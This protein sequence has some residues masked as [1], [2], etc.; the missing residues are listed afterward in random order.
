MTPSSAINLSDA[1]IALLEQCA[2]NAWPALVTVD[3][4]GWALR[5]AGG[6]TKRA[7]SANA[8]APRH[9]FDSVRR[10]A[11]AHYGALGLPTIFRLSPL[12]P[13][14]ADA[15][16]AAAGYVLVDPSLV[17]VAA[18]DHGAA[19]SGA[20]LAPGPS[21]EWIEGIAKAS[22]E[23][24]DQVD[25]HAAIL[26]A[27]EAP[28]CFVTIHAQGIAAGFGL[29]VL[30]QGRLGLFDIAVLPAA[31]GQG[32][33]RAATRALLDWGRAQG[34]R[35]A[36]LQVTAANRVARGLYGSLGFAEAYSYH[37]RMQAPPCTLA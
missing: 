19:E 25:R 27:I 6:Y 17:M 35:S 21:P 4:G 12:A 29:G 16:L 23:Y 5:S 28:A 18:L 11:E 15:T 14:C 2:L 9:P 31:R 32:W 34:A 24:G 36:Y 22:G 30:E 20:S 7:N 37:Y 26:N 33:G 13:V 1:E 8:V 10:T 3:C